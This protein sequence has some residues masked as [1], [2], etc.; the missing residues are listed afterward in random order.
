MLDRIGPGPL[1]VNDGH[2]L[3]RG[4]VTWWLARPGLNYGGARWYDPIGLNH[5]TLANFGAGSG[6]S[7]TTRPGGFGQ[8]TFDAAA[9]SAVDPA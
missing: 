8:L 5:G 6:W 9:G 3:N 2:P 4:L 1:V 7:G